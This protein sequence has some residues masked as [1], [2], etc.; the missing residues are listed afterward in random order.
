[1]GLEIKTISNFLGI[2][3]V[4]ISD[5]GYPISVV[6]SGYLEV[7][8]PVKSLNQLFDIR[9]NFQL[10]KNYC[11]RLGLTGVVVFTMETSESDSQAQMRHFAPSVGINEDPASGG[12][13]VALG[14]YLVQSGIIPAEETTRIVVEQGY[15]LQRPGL[16]YVHIHSYKKEVLR[17]SFGGQAVIT[18]EG[19]VLI[20]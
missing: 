4:D 5:T 15:A 11:Q 20:P 3:P 9:P 12:A 13:A 16:I 19:K 14:Y 1:M 7:V 2:S 17:V 10:M 18:F 6:E 8:V